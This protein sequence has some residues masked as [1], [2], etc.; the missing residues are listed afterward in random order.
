MPLGTLTFW[1]LDAMADDWESLD[2]I[3]PVVDRWFQP[4]PRLV[5][6][7]ELVRLVKLGQ[8]EEMPHRDRGDDELSA[9]SVIADPTRFWFRMTSQGRKQWDQE[10]KTIELPDEA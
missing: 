4:T 1:I 10:A 9:A 8:L 7:E 3:Q 6:A 5:V 2:Q